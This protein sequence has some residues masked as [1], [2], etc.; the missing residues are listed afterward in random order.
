[1]AGAYKTGKYRNIFKEYGYP[2]EEIQKRVEDTFNTIFYGN[3]DE[4]F[5]HEAGDDMGYMEDTGNHDVRTE[6]MSYGMMVCVQLD[7]KAEFDRLWKWVR[8]YMYIED[9]PAKNYFAWSCQTNGKRNAEGPAPDGEEYFAMALFF[10]SDQ[11]F[12]ECFFCIDELFILTLMKGDKG[13]Y[14][15]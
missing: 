12:K 7:K 13:V 15:R 14:L 8:T 3:D 10:A 1:M 2:E 6:G 9:G 5:Y 11:F 4:R